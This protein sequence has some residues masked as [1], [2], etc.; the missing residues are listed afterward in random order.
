MSSSFDK[1]L[2]SL[3]TNFN[4]LVSKV[5]N[6]LDDPELIQRFKLV[7][8]DLIQLNNTIED[9]ISDID[10]QQFNL[11]DIEKQRLANLEHIDQVIQKALPIIT[12]ISFTTDLK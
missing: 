6:H 1:T 4:E 8:H 10:R 12:L 11:S 3:S 2:N 7:H 5:L 9:L